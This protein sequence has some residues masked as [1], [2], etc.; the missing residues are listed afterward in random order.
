MRTTLLVATLI[1]L[2]ANQ[3]GNDAHAQV[4]GPQP[5]TPAEQFL[6]LKNGEVMRGQIFR[7]AER[8]TLITEQGSRLVLPAER[9]DFI[10]NTMEEAYWGKAA[11]T[12]ASDLGG[13]KRLFHWCLKNK[14]LGQAQNQI[15][16]LL[17]S[18]AKAADL[19]YLDRQLSVALL[20]QRNI[21]CQIAL[22]NSSSSGTASEPEKSLT[23]SI[24]NQP[25]RSMT[26]A[27]IELNQTIGVAQVGEKAAQPVIFR[28][29]PDLESAPTNET[30]FAGIPRNSD[31]PGPE[32]SDLNVRQVG[33]EEVI[34]DTI[35]LDHKVASTIGK[36]DQSETAEPID[37]R[38]MIPIY[39]LD[40]ETRSMPDGALGYYR[41][42]VERILASGCSAAK[43]HSDD[44]H[45]MPLLQFGRSQAIP[46]RQSQRNLHNVL[47][48]VDRARPFESRLLIAATTPHAGNSKP[49][50]E[51]GS[52]H[53][54]SLMKWLI[55]LSDDPREAIFEAVKSERQAAVAAAGTTV[56]PIEPEPDVMTPGRS[57]SL[58]FPDT[59]GEIPKLDAVEPGFIPMDPFDP[60]IFNRK[61][62]K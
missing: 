43:C 57:S 5:F 52:P 48:Y 17:Q 44:S 8:V 11:R 47:K 22:A 46:R 41:Q 28:P 61:Y 7:N 6:V 50:L 56:K 23:P 33:F 19:E 20:Q 60:E 37:D 12:K 29:L 30:Q 27:P 45:V 13:Q 59:I 62:G 9:T 51:K 15:D 3:A 53:H 35:S 36:T 25:E 21:D 40:R 34:L 39:E 54:E 31:L 38:F 10:C 16:I 32:N 55:M 49:I 4:L 2:S 14:M 26:L 24:F 1:L 42:R 18:D 58:D